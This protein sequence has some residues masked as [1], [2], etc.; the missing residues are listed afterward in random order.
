MESSRRDLFIDMVVDR[1]IFFLKKGPNDALP[2][3]LLIPKT[4]VGL[5]ETG[6]SFSVLLIVSRVERVD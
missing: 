3:L 6:V 1:L 2:C 4:G 5:S